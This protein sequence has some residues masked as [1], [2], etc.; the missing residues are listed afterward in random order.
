MLEESCAK[1]ADYKSIQPTLTQF[2]DPINFLAY[3]A[4]RN[5]R[6]I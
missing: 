3:I 2:R 5:V 6:T 4:S 1:I